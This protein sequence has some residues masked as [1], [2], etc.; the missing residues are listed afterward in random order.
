MILI[1]TFLIPGIHTPGPHEHS[2]LY[3]VLKCSLAKVFSHGKFYNA[4][5]NNSYNPVH[6]ILEPLE[7]LVQ[8]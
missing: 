7:V 5:V 1:F 6:N 2:K 8:I 4:S 3:K